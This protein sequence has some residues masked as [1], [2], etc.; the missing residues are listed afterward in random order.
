[1]KGLVFTYLLTYGGALVAIF[2]PFIGLLIYICFAILKP[3]SV[4]PWAVPSGNYS[5]TVAIALVIGWA[6]QGFGRWNLG[7]AGPRS[8]HS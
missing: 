8:P 3:E 7:A 1:M 6:F 2:K 4:W 5:R